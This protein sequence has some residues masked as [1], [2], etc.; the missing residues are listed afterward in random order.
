MA[1]AKRKELVDMA[2]LVLGWLHHTR[3]GSWGGSTHRGLH[4]PAIL[5]ERREYE[6]LALCLCGWQ[7]LRYLLSWL[8]SVAWRNHAEEVVS[9]M[10][11]TSSHC[12]NHDNYGHF[13]MVKSIKIWCP[14]QY[15]F[16]VA[17]IK[18]VKKEGRWE[19]SKGAMDVLEVTFW[20]LSTLYTI[21]LVWRR[22]GL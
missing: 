18:K 6:D 9:A 12:Q 7:T 10:F 21:T 2:A 14:S 16:I 15:L 3:S 11:W 17:L 1:S 4:H 13:P 19:T 20:D 5:E 8:C 22:L